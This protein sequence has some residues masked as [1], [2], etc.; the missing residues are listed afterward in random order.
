[1]RTRGGSVIN[2]LVSFTVPDGA[3]ISR[4]TLSLYSLGSGPGITVCSATTNWSEATVNW[5]GAPLM[6]ATVASSGPIAANS[7]VSID[8]T[9]YLASGG[10]ASF[11]LTNDSTTV[12]SFGSK[13][14]AATLVPKL[15]ITT[16]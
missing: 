9:S 7:W 11:Y 3:D 14:G 16:N 1:M 12:A 4:A 8:V 10:K 6:G 13:E 2:G 15:R 5:A